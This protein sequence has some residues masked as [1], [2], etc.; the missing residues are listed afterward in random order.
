MTFVI[1]ALFC[2]PLA[3]SAEDAISHPA[4]KPIGPSKNEMVPSLAVLNAKGATLQGNKLT[5][6]GVSPNSIVF[7]DRP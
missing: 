1:A 4:K 6:V 2:A 3:A 5:L 7:A